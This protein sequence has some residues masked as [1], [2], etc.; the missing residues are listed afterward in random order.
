VNYIVDRFETV[1]TLVKLIGAS[2][3][4]NIRAPLPGSEIP[5]SPS[6]LVAITEAVMLSPSFRLKGI[7]ANS[8]NE[9]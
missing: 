7:A 1:S 2:G 6:K 5:E 3:I 9:M 4:S 8:I